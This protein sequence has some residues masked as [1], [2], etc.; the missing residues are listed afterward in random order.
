MTLHLSHWSLIAV[1]VACAAAPSFA[2]APD[3]LPLVCDTSKYDAG[4][5]GSGIPVDLD[6]YPVVENLP[7]GLG[8]DP[9]NDQ[10]YFETE[11]TRT[12]TLVDGRVATVDLFGFGDCKD[13][14]AM[15]QNGPGWCGQSVGCFILGNA[16]TGSGPWEYGKCL[17]TPQPEGSDSQYALNDY[18]MVTIRL[19]T[20][21][22][23]QTN[24]TIADIDG[25]RYW[26][27]SGTLLGIAADGSIVLPTNIY[28]GAGLIGSVATLSAAD[29]ATMGLS[30]PGGDALIPWVEWV[31]SN[32]DVT[33]VSEG[34]DGDYG[35]LSGVSQSDANK[36]KADATYEFKSEVHGF[37]MGF[38]YA[39][40]LNDVV[41]TVQREGDHQDIRAGVLL[42]SDS[43]D[44][45]IGCTATCSLVTT[46]DSAFLT[47]ESVDPGGLTGQCSV[48]LRGSQ[49]FAYE[50][51]GASNCAEKYR[52][53]WKATEGAVMNDGLLPCEVVDNTILTGEIP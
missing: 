9:T 24:V 18:G 17:L 42:R 7:P 44:A 19:S 26:R 29:G 14:I 12:T 46:T 30:M 36:G 38:T 50:A 28:P 8:V 23:L 45:P 34:V 53:G 11:P 25:G 6:L 4:D 1:L 22:T 51:G 15:Y 20:P 43:G 48:T 37:V 5:T 39:Q 3:P 10:V 32:N 33:D 35:P 21:T 49:Y 52:V 41:P 16:A 2:Q 27:E 13:H 47:L 40:S 31:G